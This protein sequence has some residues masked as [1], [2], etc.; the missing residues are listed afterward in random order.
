MDHSVL[1]HAWSVCV[2]FSFSLA[3]LLLWVVSEPNNPSLPGP[4]TKEWLFRGLA[5]EQS[6]SLPQAPATI[7]SV[8]RNGAWLSI[9]CS[10]R[11]SARKINSSGCGIWHARRG[12]ASQA[13]A[14]N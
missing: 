7:Y 13:R 2:S 4:E 9:R 6:L 14:A 11:F 10:S 3:G 1:L 8:G 5:C 12:C